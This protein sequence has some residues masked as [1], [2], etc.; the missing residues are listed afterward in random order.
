[1]LNE[2]AE[3]RFPSP[4]YRAEPKNGY[5]HLTDRSSE[6]GSYKEAYLNEHGTVHECGE[7][8]GKFNKHYL[9]C[10]TWPHNNR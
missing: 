7:C 6:D 3:I 4:M 10:K 9:D 8:G 5:V 2:D 1:M